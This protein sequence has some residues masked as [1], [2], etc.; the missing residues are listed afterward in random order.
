MPL[1]E[2][3]QDQAVLPVREFDDDQFVFFATR[4][5]TVKKTPLTDVLASARSSGIIAIDLD[6]GDCAGRRR[7]DRRPARHHAVR[8][9]RQGDPLRRRTKCARWA[10]RPPA[11]AASSLADGEEVHRLIVVD[12]DGDILTA[13]EAAT[14]SARRSRSTRA[15]AAAARA[16]SRC[17]PPSATASWSARCQVQRRPR[18]HADHST[19]HAGAHAGRRDLEV[20]RNTQ[21]VRLIRLGRR[22]ATRRHRAHRACGRPTELPAR[23]RRTA[24]RYAGLIYS[25]PP[26][27]TVRR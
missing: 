17:R 2:G 18:G 12:G 24:L 13:R 26:G 20:G 9:R 1:E 15:R 10:A 4:H 11:C 23:R 21:G 27:N 25:A 19:R 5:G 7:A 14:A 16:S 22:R 8:Q 6:E 3:E